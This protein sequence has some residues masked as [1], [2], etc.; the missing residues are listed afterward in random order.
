MDEK[1]LS[2]QPHHSHAGGAGKSVGLEGVGGVPEMGVEGFKLHGAGGC[3]GAGGGV[4]NEFDMA[5]SFPLGWT[6]WSASISKADAGYVAASSNAIVRWVEIPGCH[7]I[8]AF[9]IRATLH[10]CKPGSSVISRR[11]RCPA[12][13]ER[14]LSSS[15]VLQ[16]K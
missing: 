11:Y 3:P 9:A 10:M 16:C 2:W 4:L 7:G 1:L 13:S 5:Q 14:H 6:L 15:M 8:L 12:S